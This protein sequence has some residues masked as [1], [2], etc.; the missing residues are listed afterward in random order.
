MKKETIQEMMT[1]IAAAFQKE[2]PADYINHILEN[3]DYI[4][5]FFKIPQFK[6]STDSVQRMLRKAE[7]AAIRATNKA[8]TQM[9]REKLIT[10]E[11]T[12]TTDHE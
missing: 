4:F 8:Y 1:K 6:P 10:T 5:P 3:S 11:H 7:I 9:L 2:L 12:K